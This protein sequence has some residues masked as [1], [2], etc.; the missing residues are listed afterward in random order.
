[1]RQAF[2]PGGRIVGGLVKN[3]NQRAGVEFTYT[4][5]TNN[6]KV[7][8]LQNLTDGFFVDPK[9][10]RGAGL[11]IGMRSHI[12][13][14]NYRHSL[15]NNDKARLYLTGGFNVTIFTPNNNR[16][17][18]LFLKP[19]GNDLKDFFKESPKLKTVAAPGVNFGVGGI[20]K[21]TDSVGLRLD[22][23][24]YLTFT[25]RVKGSAE[26]KGDFVTD[27]G[28]PIKLEANVNL[29]GK[30]IHN[31]VPTIGIVYTRR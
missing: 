9:L 16:L 7:T 30:T 26:I 23:R 20:I 5:G 15:V 22:I 21:L 27:D 1:M 13:G 29:F 2:A 4:Y 25:R 31:V 3:F 28:T 12:G 8:A 24:D 14:I 10:A 19:G 6:F 18:E 11:S 17:T